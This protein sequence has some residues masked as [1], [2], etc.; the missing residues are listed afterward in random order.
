MLHPFKDV[1][2]WLDDIALDEDGIPLW[3]G[4]GALFHDVIMPRGYDI[5]HVEDDIM[6]E[7]GV[8]FS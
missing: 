6:L 8:M 4:Y 3:R 7:D 2:V 5:A 1:T